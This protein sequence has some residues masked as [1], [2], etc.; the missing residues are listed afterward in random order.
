MNDDP[1]HVVTR[2]ERALM[3][4]A[5]DNVESVLA[6]LK[7]SRDVNDMPVDLGS[8]VSAKLREIIEGIEDWKSEVR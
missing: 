4:S 1:D 3:G 7:K 8:W 6:K 5:M 2:S